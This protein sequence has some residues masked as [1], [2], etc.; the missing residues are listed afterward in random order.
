M[1]SWSL[2]TTHYVLEAAFGDLKAALDSTFKGATTE[3]GGA[4][5]KALHRQKTPFARSGASSPLPP[6][7]P[8]E[9]ATGCSIL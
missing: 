6:P 2:S 8:V 7:P 9:S 3:G 5:P 4:A 1:A